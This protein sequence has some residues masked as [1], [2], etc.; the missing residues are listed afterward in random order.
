MFLSKALFSHKATYTLWKSDSKKYIYIY[1]DISRKLMF[2][3][4]L[5]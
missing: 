4:S 1:I 5:K 3:L 2:Q